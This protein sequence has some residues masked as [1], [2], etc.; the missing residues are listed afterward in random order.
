MESSDHADV[1]S[2][3]EYKLF[4]IFYIKKV[5]SFKAT[6]STSTKQYFHYIRQQKALKM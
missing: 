4:G 6:G 3:F 1:H 2:R 5:Q